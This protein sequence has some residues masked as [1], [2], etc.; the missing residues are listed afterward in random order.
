MEENYDWVTNITRIPSNLIWNRF[1][2]EP[3]VFMFWNTYYGHPMDW[4]YDEKLNI[5][6]AWHLS[7]ESNFIAAV[8]GS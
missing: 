8:N 6:K 2:K 5:K 1:G 4:K 7:Y 3:K